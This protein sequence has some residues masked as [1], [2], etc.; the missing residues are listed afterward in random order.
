MGSDQMGE[1]RAALRARARTSLYAMQRT[2]QSRHKWRRQSQGSAEERE[3]EEETLQEDATTLPSQSKPS[4]EM[5]KMARPMQLQRQR[6]S[7]DVEMLSRSASMQN[8]RDYV[9]LEFEALSLSLPERDCVAASEYDARHVERA[10]AAQLQL[11]KLKYDATSLAAASQFTVG[12]HLVSRNRYVGT[13]PPFVPYDR[14]T[15]WKPTRRKQRAVKK[16]WKLDDGVWAPRPRTGNSHDYFETSDA[17]RRLVWS[18][19]SM[20]V[21]HHRLANQIVQTS[22]A[23]RQLKEERRAMTNE[24]SI[25]APECHAVRAALCRHARVVMG[26]FDHYG[27]LSSG[28]TIGHSEIGKLNIFTIKFNSFMKFA[29]DCKIPSADFEVSFVEGVWVAVNSIDRECPSADDF[30]QRGQLHRHAWLG[31]LVRIAILKFLRTPESEGASFPRGNV[32][33]AVDRLCLEHLLPNLPPE[34]GHDGNAFRKAHCYAE[35]TDHVLSAHRDFLR[36]IYDR[37]AARFAP[38]QSGHASLTTTSLLSV[39]GWLTF[40]EECGLV[41]LGLLSLTTATHVFVWSRLRSADSYSRRGEIGMRNLLFEDFLE[42]IVRVAALIALP[43]LEEIEVAGAADAGEF[44]LELRRLVP[45]AYSELLVHRAN[46]WSDHPRQRIHKCIGHLLS[47]V[48]RVLKQNGKLAPSDSPRSGSPPP[49]SGTSPGRAAA[50]LTGAALLSALRSADENITA[51][52]RGVPAFSRLPDPKLRTLIDRLSIAKFE[53]GETVFSQGDE[54]DV[55]YLITTGCARV[56]RALAVGGDASEGAAGAGAAEGA[57][58]DEGRVEV[59]TLRPADY[60]GERALLT[61]EPR[62]ATVEAVHGALFVCYITRA[63]FEAI[64]GRPLSAYLEA[65]ELP[66]AEPEPPPTTSQTQQA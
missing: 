4:S 25:D 12:V 45:P 18:D 30:S 63:E 16:A 24:V 56:S 58:D 5:G 17:L 26:A 41:E 38:T 31:A 33:D 3:S 7:M 54:G 37:Y 40:V 55:F 34:A 61:S 42:A 44:L 59:A 27:M 66:S 6:S 60:F 21:A 47:L 29:H 14:A 28:G 57:I 51:A 10:A 52:L 53:E 35:L 11:A 50:P 20:S 49:H 13:A 8:A 46:H 32:A 39:D 36:G 2:I 48:Q 23:G 9:E 19:W 1:H 65:K 62:V 64:L 43:T 15:E 22:R